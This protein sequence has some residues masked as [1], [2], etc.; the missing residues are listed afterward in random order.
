MNMQAQDRLEPEAAGGHAET[1]AVAKSTRARRP[2]AILAVVLLAVVGAIGGYLVLTAGEQNTDDAQVSADLVP[3][4]ARVAGPVVEVAIQDNQ[5]VKKGDLI[6]RIDDADYQAK[7]KQAEAE[8]GSAKALAAAADAQVD[9]VGATSKGSL[10][11][12]KAAY[13]G[14]SVG[15]AS[16]DA[17]L[18]AAKAQR[19]RAEADARKADSDLKRTKELREAN[20]APQEKLDNAQAAYDS[21]QASLAQAAAQLA[22]IDELKHAAQARVT[23]AA[24]RVTQSA[25]I[26]AQIAAARANADLSRARVEGAEA[27]LGLARLQLS[28]TKITA[29]ADGIASKLSVHPGQFMS[30]GQPVV[31]LVPTTTYVIANFKETQVG[32]MRPGQSARISIDAFPHREFDGRVESLSGG[33]GSSF[34]LLPADNASG[35]FVKVVQRVPVRIAWVN[36][37]PDV[38]LR[39]GLSV[40][41]TVR[42]SK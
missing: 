4:A 10:S 25:P 15:V 29:P 40:D 37:P 39:A 14:S 9:I 41:A 3:I 6:A 27:A 42:V 17:Q 5:L 19:A 23:E 2:F 22:V 8:L 18:A 20:A 21:A 38:T 24:G 11:S 26:D 34:S 35:N 1:K 28:Y 31:E 13:S 12:A 7:V 30:V 36:L 33:T 32:Q 16:A